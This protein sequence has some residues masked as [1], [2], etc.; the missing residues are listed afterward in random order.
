MNPDPDSVPL[1]GCNSSTKQDPGL[2]EHHS[3][4]VEPREIAEWLEKVMTHNSLM[5]MTHVR[6]V[7]AYGHGIE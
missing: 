5:T 2:F 3:P 6:G 1:H 7:H 4:E